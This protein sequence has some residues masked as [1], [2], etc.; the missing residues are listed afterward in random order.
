MDLIP[1]L[2]AVREIGRGQLRLEGATWARQSRLRFPDEPGLPWCHHLDHDD[3]LACLD[4][5]DYT[6]RREPGN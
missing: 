1:A 2:E 6:R 4:G 5:A 3:Y